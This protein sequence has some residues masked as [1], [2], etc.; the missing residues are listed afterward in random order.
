MNTVRAIIVCLLLSTIFA[1]AQESEARDS[2]S[3]DLQNFQ[4]F[5]ALPVLAYSEDTELQYGGILVLFF[6][7]IEGSSRVSTIDFVALG[8][9]RKQFGARISPNFWLLEDIL[10]IPA[11]FKLYKWN[12]SLYERGSR[13]D[14]DPIGDYETS[15]LQGKIPLELNFGVP[16]WLPL[17]YGPVLEGEIRENNLES[18]PETKNGILLGGGYK[19]SLDKRDN[20]N[21][22][23]KGYYAAF[24]EIFYGKD[25]D[26]HTESV[27]MRFYTPLFWKT[28]LALGFLFLQSRG[29]KIP[30]GRLAGPDGTDRF[31]GV[32]SGLWN[33]NQAM[34]FQMEFRRPLFWRLA[35]TIF[36]ETYQSGPYFSEM[37][38]RQMH[39]SI[40]FGGR[41]ALNQSEKLH[42]RGDIS[43]IDGKH[44]GLTINLREAF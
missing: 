42:A 36:G 20:L 23:T 17:R 8:T 25:F 33:D 41:L 37:F 34:T 18:S 40:G 30:L 12:Y 3:R 15:F 14:F 4:R 5:T 13:G 32:E 11:V 31:R 6:K 7:P 27:D 44:I 2:D 21:W 1:A 43:L 24:E 39:Y 35:G 16:K 28:S 38:R 22:P 9:T 26:F 10:H 29:N 19:F